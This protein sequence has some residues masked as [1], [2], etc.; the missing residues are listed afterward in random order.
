[1]TAS[2]VTRDNCSESQAIDKAIDFFHDSARK[3]GL[4][5]I[6]NRT[7]TSRFGEKL[8]AK[9]WKTG[10]PFA[11]IILD[12]DHFKKS[13]AAGGIKLATEVIKGVAAV[14]Q[15]AMRESDVAGR[16]GR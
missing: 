8:L 11:A 14:V 7:T 12:I 1:M 10:R 6:F 15:Q 13:T 5:Q 2:V 16:W 9:S 4:T 3:D